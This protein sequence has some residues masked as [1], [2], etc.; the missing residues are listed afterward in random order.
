MTDEIRQILDSYHFSTLVCMAEAAGLPTTEPDGKKL[1]KKQLIAA[2]RADYFTEK[3]V[4]ASWE[5][6]SE[7]ERAA[8]N[9]ILLR[10]GSV[11]TRS[12]RRELVRAELATQAPEREEPRS[13]YYYSGVPYD[14]GAYE[15]KPTRP[16]S[17]VFEDVMARLTYH[18]LV[19]SHSAAPNSVGAPFKIQ[20]HPADTLYVPQVVRQYLPEPDPVASALADWQPEWVASGASAILL[21]DMYL[22]WDY[23]RKNDMSFIQA[24]TVAKRHLQAVNEILLVPDPLLKDARSETETGRLYLLRQLLGA[25]RLVHQEGR[26]LLPAGESVPAAPEFWGKPQ[27]GQLAACLKAWPHL[28]GASGLPRQADSY[29]AR[30]AHARKA[31]LAALKEQRPGRW[32]EPDE[33]LEQIQCRDPD[34]LFDEHT[35][36]ENYRLGSYYSSYAHSYYS[37][38]SGTSRGRA[39]YRGCSSHQANR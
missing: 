6:L 1:R 17:T 4:R 13:Y 24:G 30:H 7:R 12:L 29:G 36:V 37:G 19:F 2:M 14:R 10:G 11:A 39:T 5:R 26:M 21:R 18:G 25:C 32:I 31:L 33:L 20:F 23:T 3:R 34:F 9:R 22:Y 35:R 38:L 27:A 16:K 28:Q 8:V 15:G